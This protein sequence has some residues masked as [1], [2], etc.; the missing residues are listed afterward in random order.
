MCAVAAA[1]G[2]AGV[3]VW[4]I[5]SREWSPRGGRPPRRVLM[6]AILIRLDRDDV[7][8]D[9]LAA[10]GHAVA[11]KEHS[12]ERVVDAYRATYDDVV[13]GPATVRP[14]FARD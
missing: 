8:R 1:P 6:L 4:Q 10:R 13:H 7:L 2:P 12:W 11:T 9:L 3:R 14:T 5:T